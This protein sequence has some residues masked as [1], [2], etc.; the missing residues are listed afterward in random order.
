MRRPFSGLIQVAADGSS[1]LGTTLTSR[2][3]LHT[4]HKGARWVF[5]RIR[6]GLKGAASWIMKDALRGSGFNAALSS[7]A[8]ITPASCLWLCCPHGHV[9]TSHTS[10]FSLERFENR[11]NVTCLWDNAASAFSSS[12]LTATEEGAQQNIP[13]APRGL[14]P[15]WAQLCWAPRVSFRWT[16]LN[17]TENRKKV[18]LQWLLAL[19]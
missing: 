12:S 1:D 18:L 10:S 9:T 19:L 14:G 17:Q 13:A 15:A 16:K 3:V 4:T 5:S 7:D 11:G 8:E 2:T 6:R